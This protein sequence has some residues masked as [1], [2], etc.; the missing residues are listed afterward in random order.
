MSAIF[1]NENTRFGRESGAGLMRNRCA[2][3][4]RDMGAE[5]GDAFTYAV[6]CGWGSED[7]PDDVNAWPEQAAKWGWDE[8]LIEFLRDSHERFSRLS[9]RIE[10]EP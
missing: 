3:T 2:F 10:D 6:V 9:A 4:A 8:A 7:D 1:L 5:F